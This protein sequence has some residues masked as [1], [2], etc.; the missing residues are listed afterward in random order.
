MYPLTS[1]LF[2][3]NY[4]IGNIQIDN[5]TDHANAAA[6]LGDMLIAYGSEMI[7]GYNIILSDGAPTLADNCDPNG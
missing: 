2:S 5:L 7:N 3:V 6:M 1:D 4:A